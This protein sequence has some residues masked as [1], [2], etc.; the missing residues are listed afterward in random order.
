MNQ[1]PYTDNQSENY[2]CTV[3]EYAIPHSAQTQPSAC[4]ACGA[5]SY[6]VRPVRLGRRMA[7]V[8][9]FALIP[10]VLIAVAMFVRR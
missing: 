7:I 5:G 6:Y 2:Y 9:A 1:N 3:C 8:V 4:P 10:V